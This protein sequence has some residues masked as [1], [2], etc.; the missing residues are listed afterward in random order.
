ML[1]GLSAFVCALPPLLA[2]LLGSGLGW[3]LWHLLR[4][5]RGLAITQIGGA[6]ALSRT[7]ASAL[8]KRSYLHLGALVVDYLRL[9]LLTAERARELLGSRQLETLARLA[10]GRGALILT[11]HLGYWDLL[12][13]AAAKCGLRVNVITREIRGSRVNQ[14]WMAQRRRCGVRLLPASGVAFDVVR[15]LRRGEI[16]ALALDQH[17]PG[18]LEVPF[19][20]RRAA[21]STSLARLALATGAPVV[22]AFLVRGDSDE[23]QFCLG[24]PI[25]VRE[26]GNATRDFNQ[27]IEAAVRLHPEQWFWVHRRWKVGDEEAWNCPSQ[28]G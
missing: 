5:R 1:G 3:L 13:C 9:P 19:F 24:E 23:L 6:L 4:I 17:Q 11:A 25:S 14:F 21:T 20:R 8:A 2:T 12:A 7:A 15:A 10:Q 28:S 18:G 22:P 26:V 27:A 16:V